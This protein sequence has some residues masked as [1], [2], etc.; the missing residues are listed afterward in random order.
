MRS[1]AQ[2]NPGGPTNLDIGKLTSYRRDKKRGLVPNISNGAQDRKCRFC[3]QIGHGYNSDIAVR[4]ENAL[5]STAN[6]PNA[7]GVVSS[8][9]FARWQ[10]SGH[11]AW[12]YNMTLVTRSRSSNSPLFT[13]TIVS[14]L[15][16]T[17][18]ATSTTSPLMRPPPTWW[19]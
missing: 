5:R 17:V 12:Q 7:L 16:M 6:A 1:T 18:R 8:P 10:N 2:L 15:S 14:P 4:R 19:T 3:S 13:I 11:K 9:I